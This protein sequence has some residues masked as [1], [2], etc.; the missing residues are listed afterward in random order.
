MM[1]LRSAIDG[2]SIEEAGLRH[3]PGVYLAAI[4]RDGDARRGRPRAALRVTTG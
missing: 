1:V 4:E 2:Q 3:L